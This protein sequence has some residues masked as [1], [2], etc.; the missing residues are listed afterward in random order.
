MKEYLVTETNTPL[1]QVVVEKLKAHNLT[2]ATAESCTGGGLG[3]RI[4]NVPG[5]SDVFLGGVIAYSNE[6]KMKLLGVEENTLIRHG[7]VAKE[8]AKEMAH[9]IRTTTGADMGIAITGIAGPGGGVKGKP[10]G[11][12]FMHLST[13]T[14]DTG[15]YKIFPGQRDIVKTRTVNHCLYLIYKHLEALDR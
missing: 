8:T 15:E 5:S 7:A 9:G 1:E 14:N 3:N 12:V 2:L 4:T 10:V 11:L 6:L 13:E